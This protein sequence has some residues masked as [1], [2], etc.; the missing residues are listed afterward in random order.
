MKD[1]M[2]KLIAQKI[3]EETLN[4][5]RNSIPRKAVVEMVEQIIQ[6]HNRY[7]KRGNE[8]GEQE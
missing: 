7:F 1:I 5:Y 2:F 4:R 3:M 8:H 6:E